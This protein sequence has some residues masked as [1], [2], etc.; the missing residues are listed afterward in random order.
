LPWLGMTIVSNSASTLK[1]RGTGT[2]TGND[3]ATKVKVEMDVSNGKEY[4]L[5]VDGILVGKT[6][7]DV[8]GIDLEYLY[9]ESYNANSKLKNAISL[10]F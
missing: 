3:N 2:E 10:H 9:P 1:I 4:K 8:L 5:Y 6:V 7:N